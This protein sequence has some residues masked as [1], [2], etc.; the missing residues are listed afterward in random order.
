MTI[1]ARAGGAAKLSPGMLPLASS[2]LLPCI[3]RS[4][5][6][7]CDECAPVIFR[8]WD[9]LLLV[10]HVSSFTKNTFRLLIH[11]LFPWLKTCD[12]EIRQC[13]FGMVMGKSDLI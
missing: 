11:V 10:V 6:K 7:S 8:I 5:R 12:G 2:V 3:I 4:V 1:R 13:L 9:L